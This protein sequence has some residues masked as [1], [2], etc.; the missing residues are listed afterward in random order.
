MNTGITLK[1]LND[2]RNILLEFVGGPDDCF[3]V[4]FFLHFL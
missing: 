3:I 4:H 1:S 2:H